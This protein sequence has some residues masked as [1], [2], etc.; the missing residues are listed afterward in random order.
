MI[1]VKVV[2]PSAHLI[3]L[4][5]LG[6]LVHHAQATTRYF[7]TNGTTADS[8]ITAA[9]AYSWE[10]PDWNSTNDAAAAGGTSPTTVWT[11]GDFPKFAAGVNANGK[12]YTV[13]ANSSHVI[14]GMQLAIGTG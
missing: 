6:I 14:A 11:D 5:L 8:G 2:R 4:S 12:T 10:D 13:T 9:G 3:A 7:D 1:V